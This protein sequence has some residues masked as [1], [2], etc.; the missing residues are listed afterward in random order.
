MLQYTGLFLFV[1]TVPVKVLITAI[2]QHI[3]SGVQQVQNKDTGVVE[4]YWLTNPHIL[5]YSHQEDGNTSI[6]MF[7]YCPVTEEQSYAMN[8][9]FIVSIV[10]PSAQTLDWYNEKVYPSQE[11]ELNL[12]PETDEP[13]TDST[14]DGADADS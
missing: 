11:L 10:E 6:G 12:T 3:L 7:K 2:G 8:P 14:E 4:A 5:E 9:S 13:S 1:M